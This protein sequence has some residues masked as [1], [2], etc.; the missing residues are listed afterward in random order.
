MRPVFADTVY[1]VATARLADRWR[2]AAREARRRLG[3][4]GLVTT[5]EVL[6]E[7]LAP[8]A[9]GGP[10]VRSA[11][12]RAVRAMLSGSNVRVMPQS[13]SS[14]KRALA[15]YEA[16]GDKGYSLQDCASMNLME[17]ESITRILTND[18]RFEQEGFTVLMK[19]NVA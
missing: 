7:F 8:L 3:H 10:R 2:A 13:R 4:V 17:A 19:R 18:H 16:R 5:D 1:W 11:A 14:F 15:R 12:A 6:T 9:K